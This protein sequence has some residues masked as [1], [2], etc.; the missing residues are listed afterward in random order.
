[1]GRIEGKDDG[2][3]R[4]AVVLTDEGATNGWGRGRADGEIDGRIYDGGWVAEGGTAGQRGG[5]GEWC[6]DLPE[7][8]FF[9]S[10]GSRRA[11]P[12]GRMD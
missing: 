2:L 10:F 7:V 11:V 3:V 8:R 6:G 5:R 12:A 1:M 9:Q 4:R